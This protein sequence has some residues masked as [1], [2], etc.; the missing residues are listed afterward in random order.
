M[1]RRER[2]GGGDEA[3]GPAAGKDPLW[4][5][6]NLEKGPDLYAWQ[7][8]TPFLHI[9]GARKGSSPCACPRTVSPCFVTSGTRAAASGPRGGTAG[10]KF[11]P[12]SGTH[13]NENRP[14]WIDGGV[15]PGPQ[16]RRAHPAAG[17]ASHPGADAAAA[18]SVRTLWS[19]RGSSCDFL[20]GMGQRGSRRRRLQR[21]RRA[22]VAGAHVGHLGIVRYEFEYRRRGTCSLRR[23]FPQLRSNARAMAILL[24]IQSSY[25]AYAISRP[26]RSSGAPPARLPAGTR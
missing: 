9:S 15:E 17:M 12:G 5:G 1:P 21:S 16:P 20:T 8:T 19:V 11:V 2:G 24:A 25:A 22:Q 18:R 10:R 4:S 14:S 13:G 23:A 6:P 26:S 3:C 7:R